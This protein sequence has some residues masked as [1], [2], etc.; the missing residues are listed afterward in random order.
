M[1]LHPQNI[2]HAVLKNLIQLFVADIYES[3]LRKVLV[4]F[5]TLTSFR[6][7]FRRNLPDQHTLSI[8]YFLPSISW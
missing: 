8:G 3:H 7:I 4:L 6:C 5:L 2:R 1:N